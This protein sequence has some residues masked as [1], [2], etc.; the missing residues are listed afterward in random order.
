[1]NRGHTSGRIV[2]KHRDIDPDEIFLDSSNLPSFDESQ[3]EGRFELPIGRKTFFFSAIAIVLLFSALAVQAWDLQIAQGEKLFNQG[4][5]NHL[6]HTT[7]FQ[8]RG[9]IYDRAGNELA[10]NV[11]QDESFA[12]RKY[13]TDKGFSHILGYVSYPKRDGDGNL[14]QKETVGK[15]GV[16]LSY[17]DV[18]AG[19]T[20]VKIVESDVHGEEVSKATIVSPTD[21]TNVHLT[22]DLRLQSALSGFVEQVSRERGF[23]GGASILMDVHSGEVLALV[24]FP[25]FDSNILTEGSDS[26]TIASYVQDSRKPFLNRAVSG[27]YTPGSI[28]KPFVAVG[29]LESGVIGQFDQILSTGSIEVQNPYDPDASTIFKDWKAHGLVAIRE[30]LAVSSN[31]YFFT[32]GGGYG[33]Q[34]GLGIEAIERFVRMFGI[35]EQ[36][37]IDVAGEAEGIVPNPT[38]KAEVFNGDDW[39]L[40]DTYNTSIGQYGFQ[41]TPVQMVRAVSALANDGFL[42]QPHIIADHEA[43]VSRQITAREDTLQIVREGMRLAVTDGTAKGLYVPYVPIAA[44]TGTA[45]LGV[46]K[47]SVNSWVIGFFPYDNPQYAFATVMEKGEA[48]NTIGSVFVM[49]SLFD[50]MSSHTPEYFR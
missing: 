47:E 6:S 36:T 50:W 30:A 28:I 34:Q 35:G 25:E 12:L 13:I 41:V 46:E 5:N 27:L 29:A 44:K 33:N 23:E 17:N 48:H 18:L 9:L 31:V 7:V 11:S 42:V 10:W 39:R 15:E 1:M 4:E 26:E 8:K 2:R 21:G 22:I 37:G 45:E 32:V 20:G 49:R 24:S 14:Y 19:E 43:P 40:G 16:E 38:W 3:F